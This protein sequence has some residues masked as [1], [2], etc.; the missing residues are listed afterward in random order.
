MSDMRRSEILLPLQFNDGRD[1]P[2]DLLGDTLFELQERFG[3]VSHESQIIH[4]VW[5]DA[6]M[7]FRDDLT[8]IVVDVDATL[9]NRAFFAA[10]KPKL[11]QRF[12]QLETWITAH[13]IDLI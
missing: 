9:E 7:V 3:A 4:G 12:D 2:E 8:R 5:T 10:L 11:K 13:S 1:V 6:G